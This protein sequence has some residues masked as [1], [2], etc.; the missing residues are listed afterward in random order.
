MLNPNFSFVIL[1]Y[2]E[3]IHLPR[4]LK[5]I[6]DLNAPIYILDSGSTDQTIQIAQQ[7]QAIVH[8]NAF[9]NHP[10][11]WDFA[12]KTFDIKTPWTI[13]LD[14]DQELSVELF[15]TLK[16]FKAGDYTHINGI[17]F[18]RK[19]YFQGTWIKHGGYF[20]FYMLKMFKTGIGYS[21]L[22]ENMDHRFVV[23]GKTIIWKDAYLSEENL[24]EN[25]LNFW[26]AKHER[27]STLVAEEE[28]ERLFKDRKQTVVPQLLGNPDERRAWLKKLWWKLPLGIRPYLYFSYRMLLKR[29][30]LDGKTGIK[31]HYY[32]ALWFRKLIDKKLNQ[33]KKEYQN[34]R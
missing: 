9:V 7:Y 32:H 26:I 19:N 14:A 31:F 28:F 34:K 2:N 5:S 23:P 12:L 6:V 1:T 8:T 13:G 3:E 10:K 30:I 29:G 11:Q 22:N 25:D 15:S 4:L 20:P 16:N 33:L 18:N 21:D 17:Y 27:Y 24:K